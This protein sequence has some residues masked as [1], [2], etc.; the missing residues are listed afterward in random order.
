[1]LTGDHDTLERYPTHVTPFNVGL[2]LNNKRHKTYPVH[3]NREG[4]SGDHP[5]TSV[6][7]TLTRE[8]T[9]ITVASF[10]E[11]ISEIIPIPSQS[12]LLLTHTPCGTDPYRECVVN[13]IVGGSF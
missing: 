5:K 7:K 4:V 1:M 12:A 2:I 10:K 6:E 13:S 3:T 11:K 8:P 9:L